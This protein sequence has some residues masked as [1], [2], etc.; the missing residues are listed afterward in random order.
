MRWM[1][2][3]VLVTPL[4][5]VSSAPAAA[6]DEKANAILDKAMKAMGGEEKL[7]KIEA[8]SWVAKGTVNVGGR[9]VE[10]KSEVTVKG[11]DHLRRAFGND[12]F[13]AVV[14]IDGDK[15]WRSSEGGF[16]SLEASDLIEQKRQLY[17]QAVPVT[18]APL[19]GKGFQCEAAG[20]EK[21]GDKQAAVLKIT[22]P[23]GGSFTLAFD[24]ESGLPVREVVKLTDGRG[25]E[26]SIVTTFADYKEFGGIKKATK[27]AVD[28]DGRPA[29]R[30]EITDFKILDNV[31][32]ETFAVPK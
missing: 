24:T 11:L 29:N 17:L 28:N 18:L 9:G 10:I 12:R 16:K 2:V 31:S 20:Q 7:R 19:E 25:R 21:V 27:I 4:L 14:L 32:P 1:L 23:D 22:G 15:G 6:G 8:F 13:Q 30:L 5:V 26:H 3:V